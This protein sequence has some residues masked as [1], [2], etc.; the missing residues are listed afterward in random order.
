MAS[1][2]G[3]Q[4]DADQGMRVFRIRCSACHLATSRN[5]RVG[6]GL[7]G[8]FQRPQLSRTGWPTTDDN[9]R[10]LILEGYRAMPPFDG[11]LTDQELH[12]VIAYLKTL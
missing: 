2:P 6:P 8:V 11:V 1:V 7:Q 10:K 5:T 3:I 12:D 4:G 9:V